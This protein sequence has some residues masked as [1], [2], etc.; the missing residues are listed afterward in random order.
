[1]SR[2][3]SIAEIKKTYKIFQEII[4]TVS[5]TF[6]L[7]DILSKIVSIITSLA[8]GDSCFIYLLSGDEVIL[9]ASQNPHRALDIKMKVGEGI[10][11]WVAETKKSVAISHRAYEDRRFKV[12]NSLPEDT[13]EA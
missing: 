8:Q 4:D 13:F 12:F 2:Q 3:Q 7:R 9:K 1:M 6:D 5:N 11:G 10:T